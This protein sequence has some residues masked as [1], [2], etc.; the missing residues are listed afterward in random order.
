MTTAQAPAP[1]ITNA[2]TT[3]ATRHKLFVNLPVTDLQASIRFFEALG[4]RFNTQ[5]TDATATCMLIG[6]DAYA[7]LVT[8]ERFATFT[9]RPV[10]DTRAAVGGLYS[11]SV[12]SREAVDAMVHAAIAAGGTHASPAT[13]HGFMYEWGFHDLDGHGWGVF[14]MDPAAFQG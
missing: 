8:R 10:A 6:E 13:D 12:D 1:V 7:M 11:L 3:P 14:W 9:D 2:G 4:F 5:F